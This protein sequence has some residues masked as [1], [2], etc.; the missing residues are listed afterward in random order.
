MKTLSGDD[1]MEIG[2]RVYYYAE[3][4]FMASGYKEDFSIQHIGS[5]V[6]FGNQNRLIW[7]P[8][9]G[10]FCD[11]EYCSKHFILCMQKLEITT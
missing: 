8:K 11:E 6:V 4:L 2:E 3:W 7:S 5:A 1:L 10:Y 9:L